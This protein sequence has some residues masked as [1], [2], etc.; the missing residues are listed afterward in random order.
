MALF[1][2][3]NA[4]SDLE[5]LGGGCFGLGLLPLAGILQTLRHA[6]KPGGGLEALGASRVRVSEPAK[7]YLDRTAVVLSGLAACGACFGIFMLLQPLLFVLPWQVLHPDMEW[8]LLTVISFVLV[9]LL[10][11]SLWPLG[12]ACGLC[13]IVGAV[14]AQDAV[15]AV[16]EPIRALSPVADAVRWDVE[17]VRPTVALA[18]HTMPTLS[19]CFGPGTAAVVVA[20]C[21][22]SFGTFALFLTAPGLLGM[23]TL[24]ALFLVLPLLPLWPLATCST[25]CSHVL[26]AL[27]ECRLA[28]LNVDETGAHTRILALEVALRQL[29]HDQGMGFVIF[30]QVVHF[31]NSWHRPRPVSINDDALVF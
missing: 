24:C 10:W 13:L 25:S 8:N 6:T 17:V 27:N 28:H 4:N 1:G 19:A 9:G 12:L 11:L 31:D 30:Y 15:D 3:E 2:V 5:R 18:E 21:T 20:C 14:L 26:V 22:V 29:N 23:G 7:T 16:L